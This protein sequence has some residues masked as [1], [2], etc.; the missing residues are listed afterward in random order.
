MPA[1]PSYVKNWEEENKIEI[2]KVRW[3]RHKPSNVRDNVKPRPISY[4]NQTWGESNYSLT[5]T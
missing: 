5:Q 1:H 2:K 4:T 3:L